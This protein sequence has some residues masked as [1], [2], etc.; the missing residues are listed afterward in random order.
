VGNA[1]PAIAAFNGGE[2]SP[3]MEGRTDAEKYPIAAHIQQ[4][5]IA[6]KQ[7]PATFRP[8]TAYVQPV[9]NSANRTWL[10][11]FEFSQTQAFVLEFGDLYVRFYT[12]HGPLLITGVAAY[13]A[14]TTYAIGDTALSGGV[15]YT[16]IL[17]TTGNAPPNATYWYALAPYNGSLTT[18]I[19]EI[20]SPYAAADL[21]DSLGEFTLQIEQSGDVL[22]IA[23]GS[24]GAGYAPQTLTRFANAPPKWVFSTFMPTD[25]PF[26][27]KVPLVPGSEI[28]MGVSAVQGTAITVKS[29]GGN[30][31][32]AT[33][34]G[35]L[36]RIGTGFF[37]VTPWSNAVA[38]TVGQACSND[39][40][41]YVALNSATTGGSPPI[42]TAGSALDGI[43]G[44]RWLY[45]D[46]NYGV[47][48]ITAF[49]SG[50]QVTA[51][52]LTRFPANVVSAT[53]IIT[54]IS[55][56]SPAVVTAANGFALGDPVFIF[57][58]V[59]MTQVNQIPFT[60]SA[61]TGT[62]VNLA[63]IDSTSY[64]AYISGGTLVQNASV[65]WQLGAWSAT[66]EYPRALAFYKD[67]LFWAGK[68]KIWGSVPGNYASHT[69]DFFGQ[70]TTDSAINVTVTGADASNICWLSS[71]IILLIGTEGG[72]YGLDSANYSASPLGPQNV[73]ILKQ[74]NWRCRHIRPE[75][76]GVSVLYV[77]RAGRKVFAMDY[78]FYLNRYDSTDQSKFSYHI[79]VGG[80]TSMAYQQEPWSIVWAVRSDGTLLSYTFNRED[81]V[82]A[83]CRHNL[84]GYG[85]V[86]S[87]AVIPST[88]GLRD[89]LWM[90]VKRTINGNTARYVEYM[91]KPFEGPQAGQQGDL[92]SSAW[93]V[94]AGAQ[95]VATP[96]PGALTTTVTGL[97]YLQGQTVA[98]LADGGVQP[99]QVVPATGIITIAGA[100]T[101]V[102]V[103]LP[104]QGNLVPMRP[105]GGASVGTSQGK[106]KQGTTLVLRLVDS[107]GGQVAQLIQ[108]M[109]AQGSIKITAAIAEP[110]RTND[111]AIGLDNPP[112]I[113]SGDYPV[114][115]PHNA[116]SDQD[117]SDFYVL[118]QQNDPFPMTVAGLYPNFKTE[119]WQ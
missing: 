41:N 62:N 87:I 78:N 34:V 9:K 112:V 30:A 68:L 95:S 5:F 118:V 25:G 2:F 27:D 32:A 85:I 99:Q 31:F 50:S 82:T 6:L 110:I 104:Y 16:C 105:E 76:V 74:S 29:Y 33:D 47:A 24:A 115:F 66:T 80:I 67:R 12:N 43:G 119:E 79:S 13:N 45:T 93:Y 106:K 113:T 14:G 18:A 69:P 89:E 53:A 42:H 70:Q 55:Q 37:N 11:R 28:A 111:P 107:L 22:Y 59:G 109:N 116:E 17:A 96:P 92:Q 23:G 72:E 10:R 8:G 4:N 71:A 3:Q 83:W 58:V 97:Q 63:G 35:R 75:L 88:D 44:V 57:G 100:F 77:Q 48:Q 15:I 94:D 84:G 21:T 49:T 39:G 117:A 108:S 102:T 40:N 114:S 91:A 65:Q 7:G 52:V 46:S 56:A 101:T 90:V 19:Y 38:F 73:E 86:E 1:S 61:A 20:P 36:V 51:K 60:L 103:G 98:I 26:S 81:Q 54:A 64:T